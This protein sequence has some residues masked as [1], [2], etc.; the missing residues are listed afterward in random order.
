MI[1]VVSVALIGALVSLVWLVFALTRW[2]LR[3]AGEV[4]TSQPPLNGLPP[5][6]GLPDL[7]PVGSLGGLSPNANIGSATS[8]HDLYGS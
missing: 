1:A 7:G 8:S 3:T 6:G 4:T 5:Y 2:L